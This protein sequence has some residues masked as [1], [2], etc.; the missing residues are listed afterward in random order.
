MS[1]LIYVLGALLLFSSVVMI[2]LRGGSVGG[3]GGVGGAFGGMGGQSALGVRAGDVFTKITI[4]V[5]VIWVIS[6]GVLGI[7]MRTT[8]AEKK[9]GTKIELPEGEEVEADADAAPVKEA[10][11]KKEAD[12][13]DAEPAEATLEA[14][15]KRAAEK[16][17]GGNEAEA[18]D[19]AKTDADAAEKEEK[20]DSD[21]KESPADEK[22]GEDSSKPEAESE[23]TDNKESE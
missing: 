21:S 17:D 14:D 8:A 13:Q 6:A 1:F 11:S 4:V 19:G 16:A 5:A 22:V 9:T 3:E 12:D 2:L 7:T 10:D 15:S 18:D 20:A 23:P